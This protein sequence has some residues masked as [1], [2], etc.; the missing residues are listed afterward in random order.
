MVIIANSIPFTN[1][2]LPAISSTPEDQSKVETLKQS[3]LADQKPDSTIVYGEIL[4]PYYDTNRVLDFDLLADKKVEKNYS[5]VLNEPLKTNLYGG[6]QVFL[7]TRS[8]NENI[9][10]E[11]IYLLVGSSVE[12]IWERRITN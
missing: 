10:V 8:K 3:I 2:V 5:I 12:K 1:L 6:E 4:F 11:S 7:V 9:L